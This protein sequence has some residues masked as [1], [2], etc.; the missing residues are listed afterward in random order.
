M[1]DLFAAPAQASEVPEV[2]RPKRRSPPGA[3]EGAIML[4][5]CSAMTRI[6]SRPAPSY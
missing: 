3:I 1:T 2:F 5:A 6:T 4:A